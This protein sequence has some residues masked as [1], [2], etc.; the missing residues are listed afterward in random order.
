MCS[1]KSS[2]IYFLRLVL[3]YMTC[4]ASAMMGAWIERHYGDAKN[5]STPRW[6][7][8][9][10]W[11]SEWSGVVCGSLDTQPVISLC[12]MNFIGGVNICGSDCQLVPYRHVD[13]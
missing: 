6:S 10:L 5:E 11:M 2:L 1:D 7:E 12:P 4:F 9:T 3:V 8:D 13:L